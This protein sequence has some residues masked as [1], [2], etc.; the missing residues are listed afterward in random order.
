MG[1]A[2]KNSLPNDTYDIVITSHM[3]EHVPH[4]RLEKTIS[5]FNRIMKIGAT[6]RILVHV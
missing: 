4:F 3:L 1:K 2:W 6:I 5:E